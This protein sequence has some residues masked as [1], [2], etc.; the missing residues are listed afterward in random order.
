MG[1][2]SYTGEYKGYQKQIPVMKL[3]YVFHREGIY[4]VENYDISTSTEN[5]T[6]TGNGQ[7]TGTENGTC[8]S[9][10][11]GTLNL[12]VEP[13]QEPNYISAIYK[14][15]PRFMRFYSEYPRK[16][17]PRDAY[18]AFKSVVGNNDEMLEMIIADVRVR[19]SDH[20]Q[21][22]E[23]RYIPYPATYLRSGDYESEIFNAEN[24]ARLKKEE[25]IRIRDIN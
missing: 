19:V 25:A 17:K 3:N 20:D 14:N 7:C 24:E 8:T 18:K 10:E 6:S 12:S 11:N 5:G 1:L 13:K 2:I 21:W 23:K 9:T 22:Q 15:N 16:E 4:P